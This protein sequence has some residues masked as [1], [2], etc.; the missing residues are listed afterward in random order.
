M[1]QWIKGLL[2]ASGSSV[3]SARLRAVAGMPL[4][5]REGEM[6]SPWQVNFWGMGWPLVNDGLERVRDEAGNEV[7]GRRAGAPE[8]C[9]GAVGL[10]AGDWVGV[11]QPERIRSMSVN[12]TRNFC[13]K[14]S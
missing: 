9:D 2:E 14:A 10:V 13:I 5:E 12:E 7:G 4:H 1:T 8:D 3:T 6:F 11:E